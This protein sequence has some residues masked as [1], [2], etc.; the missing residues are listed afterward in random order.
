MGATGDHDGNYATGARMDGSEQS[1]SATARYSGVHGLFKWTSG[2]SETYGFRVIVLIFCGHHILKG[3]VAGGGSSG[4]V[5]AGMEYHFRDHKVS[6]SSLQIYQSAATLPWSIKALMGLC[7]DSFPYSQRYYKAP[8]VAGTTALALFAY[9]MVGVGP[10]ISVQV[11]TCLFF[12]VF[13][14]LSMTDLMVEA[15]YAAKVKKVPEKGPDLISFVWGGMS[16]WT[17]FST[18]F[19]GHLIE[20][21]G[22]DSCFL[23]AAPFA[24]VILLPVV[25]DYFEEGPQFDKT[26]DGAVLAGGND[27][28]SAAVETAQRPPQVLQ[29]AL[30]PG[31]DFLGDEDEAPGSRSS[32][33]DEVVGHVA[34]AADGTPNV[35]AGPTGMISS[36]RSSGH[37][38]S[39]TSSGRKINSKDL[40][41]LPEN[42]PVFYL[43]LFM[44]F[45][46]ISTAAFSVL[47]E[48]KIA[49]FA[50]AYTLGLSVLAGFTLFLR[51]IIAKMNLFFFTQNV[52]A[53]SIQGAA[54][55]F[56]TDTPEQYPA[57]PHFEPHFFVSVIGIVASV[58]SLLGMAAYNMFASDWNY[59][60]IIMVSNIV[61]IFLSLLNVVVFLR[62]NVSWGIPDA[63]FMVCSTGITSAVF[64]FGWMPGTVM[65]AQ[66]VPK[67]LES[68]MYALLAGSFNMSAMMSTY[69]GALMLEM[70]GCEPNGS[71]NEGHQ[72]E[73]L[74]VGA[75]LGSVL[76][77][78]TLFV[79]PW[80]IPNCKQT[81]K[82][83]VDNPESPTAGSIWNTYFAKSKYGRLEED[84]VAD[85][86]LR[87]ELDH[88][89]KNS[90]LTGGGAGENAVLS[91]VLGKHTSGRGGRE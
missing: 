88:A 47:N 24:A 40:L 3:F 78:V 44:G 57:G 46:G 29:G 15:V 33:G 38:Q 25:L 60:S 11:S 63:L 53:V 83:L 22:S 56:F 73:H 84:A 39:A 91:P 87:N 71:K 50:V 41:K 42:R 90:S 80:L 76:P 48:S 18:L 21:F 37:P 85:L 89:S 16:L 28:S 52:L 34:V 17:L 61:A 32:P 35:R 26:R 6:G 43:A 62:W 9:C 64:Q 54:F 45:S 81:E 4:I 65:L 7:S 86:E 36:A 30:E 51:P 49:N 70:L 14:Q 69:S 82:L 23:F 58:F 20:T 13:L 72:F 1:P 55:Y 5:G 59:Q 68:T 31:G 66:L 77:C 79:L 10:F 67:G 74:W 8:Y 12:L 2:L 27:G 19:I 75:A